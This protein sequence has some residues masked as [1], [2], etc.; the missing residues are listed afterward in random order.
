MNN[1]IWGLHLL[2][3]VVSGSLILQVHQPLRYLWMGDRGV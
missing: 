3:L 1:V 2:L